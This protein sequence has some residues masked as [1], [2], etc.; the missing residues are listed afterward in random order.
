MAKWLI[1]S[2][3]PLM[4]IHD[5]TLHELTREL[6][7]K[8]LDPD[9]LDEC[10][11]IKL[12]QNKGNS[13]ACLELQEEERNQMKVIRADA[14]GDFLVK[15]DPV[16]AYQIV[17]MLKNGPEINKPDMR[18][19]PVRYEL[20]PLSDPLP[21]KEEVEKLLAERKKKVEKKAS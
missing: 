8:R 16:L 19:T 1:H 7:E 15:D 20:D 3:R 12:H 18:R 21:T 17:E 9:A 11:Q 5:S 2:Y 14:N 10:R 4:L 13:W 6:K